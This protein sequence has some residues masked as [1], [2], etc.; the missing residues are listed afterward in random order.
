MINEEREFQ[1]IMNKFRTLHMS[2]ILPGIN[3]G[4][5]TVMKTIRQCMEKN[6]TKKV[7]VAEIV[8]IMCI[9]APAVSRCFRM[10]EGKGYIVRSIDSTDRRNVCVEM[11]EEGKQVFLE[12]EKIMNSFVETVFGEMGQEDM[13]KLNAYMR[14]FLHVVQ[15]EIEKRTIKKQG[16]DVGYGKNF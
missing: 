5:F 14:K 7:R 16:G 6:H 11:T 15:R 8:K 1:E 13:K 2:A 12:A 10:L 9:P 3:Q 4:D